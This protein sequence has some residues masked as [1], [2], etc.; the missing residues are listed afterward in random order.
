MR[1]V[2]RRVKLDLGAPDSLSQFEFFWAFYGLLLGLAVAELLG[3][4]A[5][6]LRESAPPRLGVVT[7]LLGLQILVEMLA[8]Y[9]DA[10]AILRGVGVSLAELAV[11]TFIGL[12]YYVAAV[13]IVPRQLSDWASLDD[14][15]DKRR[16]WIVGTLL[17]ANATVSAAAITI[18]LPRFAENGAWVGVYVLQVGSL[19]G[20]YTCLLLARSRRLSVVAILL[21]MLWYLVFYGPFPIVKAM[22]AAVG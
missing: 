1:T 3:G 5:A 7:P 17:L 2:G 10:W 15:F 4:F 20:A 11:P 22:V 6:L 16:K 14:Y 13:I 21:L 9:V 8:N 18:W 19:L 12:L